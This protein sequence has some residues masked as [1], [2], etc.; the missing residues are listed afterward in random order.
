MAFLTLLTQL[1]WIGQLVTAVIN[2]WTQRSADQTAADQAEASA[3]A[4]HQNDGAQSVADKVSSDSQNAALDALDRAHD[5]PPAA[6]P[7]PAKSG[8]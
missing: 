8:V 4:A 2:W 6:N 5:N 7:P 1:P 3:I